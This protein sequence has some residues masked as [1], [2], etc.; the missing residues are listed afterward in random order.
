MLVSLVHGLGPHMVRQIVKRNV[1]IVIRMYT[2]KDGDATCSKCGVSA[3]HAGYGGDLKKC[4]SCGR[5]F[6]GEYGYLSNPLRDGHC[7]VQTPSQ[8]TRCGGDGLINGYGPCSHNFTSP[9]AYCT[10]DKTTQHDD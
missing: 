5:L 7:Q 6:G 3:H 2:I 8:C 9:H 10:H 4:L 1:L